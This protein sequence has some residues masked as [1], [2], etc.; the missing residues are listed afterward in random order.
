MQCLKRG[1]RLVSA[2]HPVEGNS[3]TL[4][5]CYK[6]ELMHEAEEAEKHASCMSPLLSKS[7]KSCVSLQAVQK[8]D[9]LLATEADADFARQAALRRLSDENSHIVC[10]VLSGKAVLT[11]PMAELTEQIKAL[12]AKCR[13]AYTSGSESKSSKKGHRAIIKKVEHC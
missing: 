9:V 3:A 1:F 13:A 10:A 4:F 11:I 2:S 12:L 7:E 6:I 5:F 8:L